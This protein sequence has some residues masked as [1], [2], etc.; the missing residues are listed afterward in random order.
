MERILL[1]A[2]LAVSMLA[3]P[4]RAGGICEDFWY[5]RNAVMDR[6]GYC[7]GSALGQAVF[8]NGDCRTKQPALS[9]GDTAMVQHIQ[10]E[11]RRFSCKINTRAIQ[12]DLH[13]LSWRRALSDLPVADPIEGGCLGWQGGPVVLRAGH[14]ASS[15]AL[16]TIQPGDHVG[17]GHIPVGEWTYVTLHPPGWGPVRG[18]GWMPIHHGELP[19]ANYAG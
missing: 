17:F 8:D 19:C 9:P 18:A 2:A 3:G 10:A 6:A 4:L 1:L 7:F 16:A 5:T 15:P 12:L 13:D 11:E 14:D